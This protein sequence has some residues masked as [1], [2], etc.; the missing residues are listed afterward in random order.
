MYVV[1]RYSLQLGRNGHRPPQRRNIEANRTSLPQHCD[2]RQKLKIIIRRNPF[3]YFVI[4]RPV[5]TMMRF[6]LPSTATKQRLLVG[7]ALL[8]FFA[9]ISFVHGQEVRYNSLT[10]TH[11]AVTPRY[12]TCL[13]ST[14]GLTVLLLANT[15]LTLLYYC[16]WHGTP[17]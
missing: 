9:T 7:S 12:A 14:V 13:A 17:R 5:N 6:A 3:L 16:I 1:D 10:P 8:V 15:V 11:I 2:K 4:A